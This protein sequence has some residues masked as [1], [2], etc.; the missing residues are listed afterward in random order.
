[1]TKRDRI[2]NNMRAFCC[3][4]LA[5]LYNGEAMQGILND[6]EAMY[7]RRSGVYA[8]NNIVFAESLNLIVITFQTK[9]AKKEF[10]RALLNTCNFDF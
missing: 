4:T 1:M 6:T 7:A 9:A 8:M 2:E 10:F 3:D 5:D